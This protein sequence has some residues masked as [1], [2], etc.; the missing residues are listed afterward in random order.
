M[1]G[2]PRYIILDPRLF[3]ALKIK[4]MKKNTVATKIA[5]LKSNHEWRRYGPD[6]KLG[7]GRTDGLLA[8][9]YMAPIYQRPS[10]EWLKSSLNYRT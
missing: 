2:I 9:P 5:S 1:L 7:L 4:T 10:N 6:L 8:E 3:I